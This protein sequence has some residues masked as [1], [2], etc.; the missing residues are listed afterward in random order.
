MDPVQ[1]PMTAMTILLHLRPMVMLLHL[2]PV[3]KWRQVLQAQ[4]L[5]RPPRI[6]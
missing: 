4:K 2:R 3:V 1:M 6:S 5:K